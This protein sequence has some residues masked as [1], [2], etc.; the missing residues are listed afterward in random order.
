MNYEE[1]NKFLSYIHMGNETFRLYYKAAEDMNNKRLKKLITEIEEVFKRHEETVTKVLKKRTDDCSDSVTLMGKMALVMEKLKIIE[2][3][4]DICER[5][6]K[7]VNMGLIS[8]L[9]F[10]YYNRDMD[11]EIKEVIK[12]VIS[13]YT[14][15]Q[16]KINDYIL[17]NCIKN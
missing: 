1:M 15:I 14:D 8:G 13:D 17:V 11:E 6:I 10:A 5:A 2:T 4:F 12:D 3:E 9:K 7:A 16:E